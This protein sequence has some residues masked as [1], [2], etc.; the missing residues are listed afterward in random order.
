MNVPTEPLTEVISAK[1]LAWMLSKRRPYVERDELGRLVLSYGKV[2]RRIV[3]GLQAL[4]ICLL[5]VSIL[6]AWGDAMLLALCGTIFGLMTLGGLWVLV[7][8]Y[9]VEVWADERGLHRREPLG[10]VHELEWSALAGLRYSYLLSALCLRS[11]SGRTLRVGIYRDG[12]ASLAELAREHLD[13]QLFESG[14]AELVEWA[15]EPRQAA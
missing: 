6:G 7:D 14:P 2:Y 8:A 3:V 15:R 13:E 9:L 1:L 10:A 5:T 4:S 11:R 12:I